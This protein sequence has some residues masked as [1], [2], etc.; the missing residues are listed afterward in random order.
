MSTTSEEIMDTLHQELAK[1]LLAK[2]KSGGAT[3]ADLNVIR[4]FLKDNHISA[5]LKEDNP[6]KNLV[7]ELPFTGDESSIYN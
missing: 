2:V 3:A 7:D 1:N 6:L 5:I 4:Q